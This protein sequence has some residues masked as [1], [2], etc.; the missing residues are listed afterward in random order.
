MALKSYTREYFLIDRNKE[1]FCECPLYIR[2]LWIIRCG[3]TS[4]L[5]L[6]LAS[7]IKHFDNHVLNPSQCGLI[8]YINDQGAFFFLV[9]CEREP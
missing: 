6:Q 2:F 5:M 1:F 7:S 9:F 8:T 4:I 3:Y